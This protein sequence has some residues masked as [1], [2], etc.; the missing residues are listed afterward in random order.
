MSEFSASNVIWTSR[1]HDAFGSVV[2]LEDE[3][4]NVSYYSVE[5]EFDVAGGSY[6]VLRAESGA[7]AE[8]EIFKIISGQD[9]VLELVTID[10]DDEWENVTELYDELT[11]PE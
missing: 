2:E 8:P 6:A 1:V 3:Q 7:N 11:F 10:D 5:K 9:G 4:G